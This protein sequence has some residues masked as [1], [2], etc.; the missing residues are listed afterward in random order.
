MQIVTR[1]DR[2]TGFEGAALYGRLVQDRRQR[3]VPPAQRLLR[4]G[5]LCSCYYRLPGNVPVLCALDGEPWH[6]HPPEPLTLAPSPARTWRERLAR[7]L[8]P[9][10]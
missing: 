5:G 9:R 10:P 6:L 3:N 8:D 1:P 7:R 4:E 2:I